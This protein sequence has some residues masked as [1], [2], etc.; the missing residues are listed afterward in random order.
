MI[1]LLELY[2]KLYKLTKEQKS[3]IEKSDFDQL[4]K[5]LEKKDEIINKIDEI[6]I[7]E[8]L[9]SQDNPKK[10]HENLKEIMENIKDLE[11]EN[12]KKLRAK[13][14]NLSKEMKSFNKKQK[15]RDGYTK[16]NAFE[17]KFIDK[18]S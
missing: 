16:G 8:Y 4:I 3:C 5:V 7:K 13:K 1:E 12:E 11:E 10:A 2:Q 15:S 9:K 18:K 6:E 17:A 14:E